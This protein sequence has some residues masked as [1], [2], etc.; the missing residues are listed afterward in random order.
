MIGITWSHLTIESTKSLSILQIMGISLL[1]LMNSKV[2]ILCL[3]ELSKRLGMI[4][5]FYQVK[6]YRHSLL[7]KISNRYTTNM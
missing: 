3:M 5:E 6:F 2:K 7:P 1:R 4:F